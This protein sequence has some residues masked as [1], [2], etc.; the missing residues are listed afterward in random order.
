[1]ASAPATPAAASMD[2]AMTASVDVRWGGEGPT[3]AWISVLGPAPTTVHAPTA[4]LG[5]G[6]CVARAGQERTALRHW[7]ET[8]GT[9]GTTMMVGSTWR[10]NECVY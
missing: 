8:V 4:R 7:R 5:G 1:M 2:G 9:G 10:N 3:A 6:A